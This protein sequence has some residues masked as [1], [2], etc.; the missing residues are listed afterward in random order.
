MIKSREFAAVKLETRY[1]EVNLPLFKGTLKL[2]VT[3]VR[4]GGLFGFFHCR[5]SIDGSLCNL[6]NCEY[7]HSNIEG[8]LKELSNSSSN[9]IHCA[10]CSEALGN[11]LFIESNRTDSV[12]TNR[13]ALSKVFD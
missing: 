1:V 5:K 9:D 13:V 3:M 4:L 7:D 8:K 11:L 6:D 10:L 12:L 2:T